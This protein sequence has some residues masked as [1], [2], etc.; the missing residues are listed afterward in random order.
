MKYFCLPTFPFIVFG[1]IEPMLLASAYIIGIYD[2]IAFYASQTP[3]HFSPA[4]LPPQAETLTLQLL[5]ILLLL[6]A[7]ALI[8]SWTL[9]PSTTKAY[10]FVVALAD[11][12]HIYAT[13]RAVESEY[14]WDVGMWNLVV[15]GN[16]GVKLVLN[17]VR[18]ATLL[19]WF[20]E[21]RGVDQRW[22]TA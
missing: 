10:L 7:M 11:Y 1:I 21:V 19:G 16:V 15:W 12:G 8:C 14:F 4:S 13:Y 9:N 2:P 5:N 22:K 17:A 6:A 18:V 3:N 20:G